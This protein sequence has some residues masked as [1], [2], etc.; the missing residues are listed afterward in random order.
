[1]GCVRPGEALGAVFEVFR[2]TG[3][4]GLCLAIDERGQAPGYVTDLGGCRVKI[5]PGATG[6]QPTKADAQ[7]LISEV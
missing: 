7:R 4:D 5:L 6:M 2:L 3:F 1:M